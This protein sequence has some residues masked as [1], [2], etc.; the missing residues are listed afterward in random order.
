MHLVTRN[1]KK[2]V[3][4]LSQHTE[5]SISSQAA[6]INIRFFVTFQGSNIREEQALG[7]VKEQSVLPSDTSNLYSTVMG[8]RLRRLQGCVFK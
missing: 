7:A 2:K 8:L 6:V 5:F 4:I 1:K 3:F